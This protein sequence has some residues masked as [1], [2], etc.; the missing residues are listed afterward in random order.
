M[1]KYLYLLII[2]AIS[3]IFF[4]AC[5][6]KETDNNFAG[7][8]INKT[9]LYLSVGETETL[10]ANFISDNMDKSLTWS[11]SKEDI[12]T[13]D[14]T[15]KITAIKPG[16]TIITVKTGGGHINICNVSV[17]GIGLDENISLGKGLNKTAVIVYGNV[18]D[19]YKKTVVASDNTSVATVDTTGKITAKAEGIANITMTVTD[20]YGTYNAT[21][22]V[23]VTPYVMTSTLKLNQEVLLLKVGA[24]TSLTPTVTP[25]NATG[26]PVWS[27]SNKLIATVDDAGQVTGII[28]GSATITATIDGI[29]ANC[30][31][32]VINGTP[33]FVEEVSLNQSNV[34]LNIGDTEELKATVLPSNAIQEI[35]WYSNDTKVA[36]VANGKITAIG[37]GTTTI[38]A[39]SREGGKIGSCNVTVAPKNVESISLNKT[40]LSLGNSLSETLVATIH[41][42]NATNKKVIWASDA[43]SVATIDSTG[44]ITIKA[45]TG[46]ATITATTEDGGFSQTCTVTALPQPVKSIELNKTT[47]SLAVGDTETLTTTI[48]PTTAIT[49]QVWLSSNSNVATVD[50]NGLVSA[51]GKGTATITVITDNSYKTSICTITVN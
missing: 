17:R 5:K 10:T 6:D 24:N 16:N 14:A 12:A 47:L 42:I 43:P 27:S 37:A 25:Q 45:E 50:S 40:T 38:I 15:G 39:A 1:K 22:I 35:I 28:S 8:T 20:K 34:S 33:V 18:V 31:V 32:I 7:V 26:M 19:R 21:S 48:S 36:T 44:K 46:T 30:S 51:I 29:S 4:T 23:T 3:A 13:V 2:I 11:S 49:N 41:P 9:S